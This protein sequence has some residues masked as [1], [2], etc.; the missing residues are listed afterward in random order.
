MKGNSGNTHRL[1]SNQICVTHFQQ[2]LETDGRWQDTFAWDSQVVIALTAFSFQTKI[3][4]TICNG[5]M[6][7][8]IY[9]FILF[10]LLITI[11]GTMGRW[12]QVTLSPRRWGQATLRA[13][14][15]EGRRRWGQATLRAGDV[16]GKFFN[17]SRIMSKMQISQPLGPK[18]HRNPPI[19]I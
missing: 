19:Y 18:T 9:V 2:T 7:C 10:G 8:V 13:G 14:D 4:F 15:V 16:E 11:L 17:F 6:F 3:D 1:F 12:E 5:L